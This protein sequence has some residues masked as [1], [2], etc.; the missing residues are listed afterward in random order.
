MELYI[1]RHGQTDWNANG[2]LQGRSDTRLN[3]N[4]WFF[5]DLVK[6]VVMVVGYNRLSLLRFCISQA[7]GWRAGCR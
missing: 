2:L 5:I 7:G 4:D 6:A 1:V 3:Q